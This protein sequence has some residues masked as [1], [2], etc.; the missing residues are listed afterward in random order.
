M[1]QNLE[2]F[3][4]QYDATVK[5]Y[6]IGYMYICKYGHT[7]IV[8]SYPVCIHTYIYTYA[9]MH[10]YSEMQGISSLGQ[11]CIKQQT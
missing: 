10:T 3:E 8:K 7:H 1:L 5:I 6:H 4:G 11:D 2:Y 9:Y